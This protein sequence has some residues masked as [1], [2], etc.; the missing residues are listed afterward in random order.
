MPKPIDQIIKNLN[1]ANDDYHKAIE[2]LLERED[3]NVEQRTMVGS[4]AHV[5]FRKMADLSTILRN[6]MS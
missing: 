3:L 6:Y 1:K 5:I 2:D 4:K